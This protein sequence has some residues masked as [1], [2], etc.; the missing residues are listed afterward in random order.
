LE[1]AV[2][3]P[4]QAEPLQQGRLFSQS[5]AWS[6]VF[7]TQVRFPWVANQGLRLRA[8]IATAQDGHQMLLQAC[9]LQLQLTLLQQE[10]LKPLL[11]L[12]LENG[13]QLLQEFPQAA[14]L[15]EG[16]RQFPLEAA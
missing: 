15:G 1:A 5:F 10:G 14:G 16:H 13:G 4:P 8:G 11:K 6:K 7:R 2:Q 12:P 3:G 9:I